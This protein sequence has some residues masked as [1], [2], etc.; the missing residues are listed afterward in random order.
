MKRA[1]G[2]LTPPVNENRATQFRHSQLY[3]TYDIGLNHLVSSSDQIWNFN[4]AMEV[5]STFRIGRLNGGSAT[6]WRI[7]GPSSVLVRWGRLTGLPATSASSP[8]ASSSPS[9]SS[10]SDWPS[11]SSSV[12]ATFAIATRRGRDV[13]RGTER[14]RPTGDRMKNYVLRPYPA[15]MIWRR[16][17]TKK[18]LCWMIDRPPLIK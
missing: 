6:A 12:F 14:R 1:R 15:T 13:G 11:S 8:S 4:A 2:G 16:L 18:L 3:R 9:S 17:R 5:L 7:R 10:S